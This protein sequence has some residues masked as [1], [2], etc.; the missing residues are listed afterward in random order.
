MQGRFKHNKT[1]TECTVVCYS[2]IKQ[3]Y[4]KKKKQLKEAHDSLE[5][6]A[7]GMKI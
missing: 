7:T 2:A 4:K 3:I 6:Q 5:L 1:K